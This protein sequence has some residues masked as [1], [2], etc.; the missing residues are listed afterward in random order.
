MCAR[1]AVLWKTACTTAVDDDHEVP[2]LMY[3]YLFNFLRLTNEWFFR[4]ECIYSVCL[5]LNWA[6]SLVISV[7]KLHQCMLFCPSWALAVMCIF[8]NF[9][10]FIWPFSWM[11]GLHFDSKPTIIYLRSLTRCCIIIIIIMICYI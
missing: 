4:E 10:L 5:W 11:R 7:H 8:L 1:R 9:M 3:F 6:H 2:S